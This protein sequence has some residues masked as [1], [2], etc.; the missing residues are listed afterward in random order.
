MM[1]M[2][3]SGLHFFLLLFAAFNAHRAIAA[4]SKTIQGVRG[5]AEQV[6]RDLAPIEES[7]NSPR[8]SV[9]TCFD[10]SEVLD[11]GQKDCN[12]WYIYNHLKEIYNEQNQL[13]ETPRCD[14]GLTMEIRRLTNTVDTTGYEWWDA[15][16]DL[17]DQA[18]ENTDALND[19]D[20]VDWSRIEEADINLEEFFQGG[21]YLNNEVG[22]LQQK[23]SEFERRGGYDRY[24]YIGEDPTMND[25]LPTSQRSVEGGRTILDFYEEDVTKKFLSSPSFSKLEGGCPETNSAVCCWSR[26]RQYN[27]NNG[28]CNA[29]GHCRNGNPG[30]NTDLC[31]TTDE[32]DNVFPYPTQETE[33][34]LHCHGYSWSDD[35]FS[36]TVKHNNLFY[37]SMYDH[38]YKR[39]YVQSITDDDNIEGN[40]AMCGC[41]EDMTTVVARADCTEIVPRANYTAYQSDD[42][43]FVVEHKAET[44]ELEYRACEGFKYNADVSP[45]DYSE[46]P[47]ANQLGLQRQNNDLSAYVYRQYLEGKKGLAETEAFEETIIGYKDPEVNRGDNEREAACKAAF[48]ARYEKKKWEAP[49]QRRHE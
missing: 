28:S 36:D 34:A 5:G 25:Y 38:L 17:C 27:D 29:P 24:H 16:R 30:D 2:K 13:E 23:T 10:Y 26:D 48:E 45:D 11:L 49:V 42:G 14:G 18:F 44:F 41:V 19:V 8:E 47:N 31:W 32:N 1:L 22:N 6:R 7:E 35:D 43:Y 40:E 33:G 21:T 39:G 12:Q 46:N 3:T 37:V 9:V 20:T 4:H 15:L